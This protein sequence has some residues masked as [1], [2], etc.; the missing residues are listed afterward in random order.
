MSYESLKY[1]VV[2]TAAVAHAVQFCQLLI[3]VKKLSSEYHKQA[4]LSG[5]DQRGLG[6]NDVYWQQFTE[7]G[8]RCNLP[9]YRL[10]GWFMG[11]GITD[12]WL[13][14]RDRQNYIQ[15]SS[16]P[17]HNR[18]LL[19]HSCHPYRRRLP[20]LHCSATP[21]PGCHHQHLRRR[22]ELPQSA[23]PLPGCHRRRLR[24]C[25]HLWR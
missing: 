23:C 24:H 25:P 17:Y 2:D 3:A 7:S 8:H 19:R 16:T 11:W 9:K 21:L 14:I 22:L 5:F 18:F 13:S 1:Q 20:V 15:V 6:G 12:R 10:G 4:I